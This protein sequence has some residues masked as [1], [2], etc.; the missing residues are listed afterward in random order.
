MKWEKPAMITP[1]SDNPPPECLHV[2]WPPPVHSPSNIGLTRELF[3]SEKTLQRT[4]LHPSSCMGMH[5][6]IILTMHLFFTF[7]LLFSK[8]HSLVVQELFRTVLPTYSDQL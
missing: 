8:S 7:P 6:S 2:F 1:C 4:S 5:N 3:P